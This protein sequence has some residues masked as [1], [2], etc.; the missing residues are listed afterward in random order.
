MKNKLHAAKPLRM[1]KYLLI[2]LLAITTGAFAQDSL[3]QSTLPMKDGKVYYELIFNVDSTSK[4]Q[5]FARAQQ[6]AL[7]NFNSQKAA[8]QIDDKEQGILAYKGFFSLQYNYPPKMGVKGTADWQY[9]HLLKI[10]VKDNKVK[11]IATD[12]SI[13]DESTSYAFS[14]VGLFDKQI[15]IEQ[16]PEALARQLKQYGYGDK[17]KSRALE[18][19]TENFKL[20]NLQIKSQM[21]AIRAA[22][23]S[24][25]ETDF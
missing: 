18:E 12:F 19:M 24:K 22:M 16:T 8:L 10:L 14:S 25:A 3:F 23:I 5:L 11:I 17:Y 20:A 1:K 4:A 21:D 2:A 9:W 13:K 6:W 7:G 15:L